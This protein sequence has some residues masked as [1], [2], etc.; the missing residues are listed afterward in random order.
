MHRKH[1]VWLIR[2]RELSPARPR[3]PGGVDTLSLRKC[4]EHPCTTRDCL[5]KWMFYVRFTP[6]PWQI[7]D[8]GWDLP[9]RSRR[10][11]L[12]R[13]LLLT[14]WTLQQRF[15]GSMGTFLRIAS[16]KKQRCKAFRS[17]FVELMAEQA[18]GC[19]MRRCGGRYEGITVWP[20][21][22]TLVTTPCNQFLTLYV[23]YRASNIMDHLSWN[24]M[25]LVTSGRLCYY[26][27]LDSLSS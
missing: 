23:F 18:T 21:R 13:S 26:S 9:W 11:M 8:S 20:V 10:A 7:H 17:S 1:W 12:R 5:L 27:R 3:W 16:L 25:L 6:L 4:D 19:Q 22:M 2:H 14:H 15:T 24:L